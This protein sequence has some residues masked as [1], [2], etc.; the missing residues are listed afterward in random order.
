MG[1]YKTFGSRF[2]RV[3]RNDLNANF[4]DIETDINAQKT[5][6]DDLIIGTPQP[7]EVV[8]SR[9]GF[10][11]LGDR[12]ED[13]SSS[14]A[15][16]ASKE[17]VANALD[18]SP[19]GVFSTFADL[20]AAYPTGATGVYLVTGNGHIYSW[21]GFVWADRGVYQA[22]GF[23]D[24]SVTPEKTNFFEVNKANEFNPDTILND[25]RLDAAGNLFADT[26]YF[27]TDFIPVEVGKTK[28][29][30]YFEA[31]YIRSRIGGYNPD[32][33]FMKIVVNTATTATVKTV[34]ITPDFTGYIKVAF[35][36][37]G[38]HVAIVAD[39]TYFNPSQYEEFGYNI[40]QL[41]FTGDQK[42]KI[43]DVVKSIPK[44][45]PL[46]VEKAGESFN[47]KSKLDDI[48][49]ITIQTLRN[50]SA[51][52]SFNFYQTLV[53]SDIVHTNGDDITPIRLFDTVGGNHGYTSIITVNM[54][55]HGKTIADLGSKWTDGVTVYT[56]LQVN[57]S[58]RLTFGCPY[59][60]V[61]GIVS[62][63]K[64][65]PVGNLTHVSGAANTSVIDVTNRS[66]L[67]LYPST[68]NISVKY[69]LDGKEI[70]SNGTYIGEELQVQESYNIMDYKSIIDFAQNNIGVS[71]ATANIAGA[72]NLSIT[73]TFTK[74]GKC[75]ISHTF[76]ALRKV[77][78][79]NC[80]FIQS[81][82]MSLTNHSVRRYMPNVKPKSGYD[83][84]SIVDL[85]TYS[86]DT[87]FGVSDYIDP[88][89]PPN[90]QVDW[91]KDVSGN[92]KV[93]FTFG[94]IV[95]KSNSKNTDRLANTPNGWDMRG[96]KKSY[97]IAMSGKT[98]N[99]G[100][101]KTFLAYRNY[102]SPNTMSGATN[103]NIVRDKK[104]TYIYI[105]FHQSVTGKNIK[106][107]N[108]IGKEITVIDS[109]NFTLLNDVVDSDGISFSVT[110]A[111]GY[112]ILKVR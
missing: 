46:T 67:Q 62:A 74:G 5:R 48:N 112:A 32:K 66:D 84:K 77:A 63:E 53:N 9:G 72:V 52:G 42:N 30:G 38:K 8:D 51:N 36:K 3:H 105:D 43:I 109:E 92:S 94:Y 81:S 107:P 12:L 82:V 55:A 97:P 65:N 49:E 35:Q 11:V 18:G 103:I 15:Q 21:D 14:L 108:E 20:Q 22:T 56:L 10:P 86:T 93:G 79:N 6:V 23:A 33:S 54:S 100:D 68:N 34:E 96:T 39:K 99:A 17:E 91:L 44:E 111:Y 50:G 76:K 37:A 89:K 59:T 45:G 29:I 41:V 61:D 87:V 78:I 4:A 27:L 31:G 19:K 88:S 98:I 26:D 70:T 28:V 24:G 1:K 71:Y 83:F 69:F 104:D 95:D 13:L 85:S 25:Y 90:R 2:D 106:L 73:Y 16:K 47:I 58:S 60:E 102:L 7:S 80:G 64:I 57:S 101:Y 40:S 75:H 110:G